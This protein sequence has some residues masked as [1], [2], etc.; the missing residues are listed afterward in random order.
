MNSCSLIV[1]MYSKYSRIDFNFVFQAISFGCL[2][3]WVCDLIENLQD[4]F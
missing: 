2:D 3:L 1:I 4:E